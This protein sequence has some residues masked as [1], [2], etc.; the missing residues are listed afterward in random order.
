[1]NVVRAF[2]AANELGMHTIA[3]SGRDGGKVADVA[4]IVIRVPSADTPR[5]QECHMLIGHTFCELV[6]QELFPEP[7]R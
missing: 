4:G 1:M 5:V 3:L 6:E 7:G 2:E